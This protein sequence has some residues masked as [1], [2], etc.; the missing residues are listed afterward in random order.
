MNSLKP[1]N[2][3]IFL[4]D[5]E[6][7]IQHFPPNWERKNLPGMMRLKKNGLSF[8]NA[9]TDSC[10]C[11]PA[12]ATMMT[13]Y[14]PAQ[15]GVKYTLE[16]DMQQPREY[17]QV[18]LPQR[19]K[20][21]ATVMS[22]A[23]YDVVYK[24]KFHLVK[25]KGCLFVPKDVGKYGF[26]RWN[27]QDAGANQDITEEGGGIIDNDGRFMY[28][29][30][31]M[32]SGREGVLAYLKK[33]AAG[34]SKKKKPFC[35]IVSI[36]NPHDVLFYPN[37]LCAGGYGKEW[38][39]G[40]IEPPKTVR[41]DLSSKPRVQRQFLKLC[42]LGM[43]E[44]KRKREQREY[45]NFYGN[46]MK[47]ADRYLVEVLTA[48]DSL[49][50]TDKTLVVR[51]SDHGEMGL[52]HGGQRQKNFN[53]Y[54]ESIRVPLVYSN[55]TLYKR[56]KTS[57]ALVSHVDFLPTLVRLFDAPDSARSDWQGVDYSRLVLDPSK[58]KPVQD[59][60]VFTYDDYQSGQTGPHPP[61]PNHI[62]SIREERYKLAEYYD[63]DEKRPREWEMYDLLR[64]PM[65]TRNL[66]A[67]GAKRPPTEQAEYERLRVKLQHVKETRLQPLKRR[68]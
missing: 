57:K 40:D 25:Y 23:G 46:L 39:Q 63:V 55:P 11:S 50:L 42:N 4:T 17:P 29:D 61:P 45:V 44:I 67:S 51:T 66:A 52:A 12:R 31:P 41:E 58:G 10:M 6:R 43:G 48:L 26:S 27:P 3:V 65:E 47:L 30:G 53:F 13:G 9:F 68:S 7:A 14:F 33:V 2:V 34:T 5:Q 54:E 20:N 36:V 56:P 35:L 15:H 24:G 37:N 62:V 22:Q 19:L 38:L 28:S 49:N 21:I 8:Q 64:D 1:L 59:Y 18:E 16:Q 60:I 32:E